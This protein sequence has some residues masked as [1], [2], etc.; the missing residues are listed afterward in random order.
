MM[1]SPN[2]SEIA[3]NGIREIVAAHQAGQARTDR[4]IVRLIWVFAVASLL[5]MVASLLIQ[6]RVERRIGE[7]A[8]AVVL[9]SVLPA[10]D[11]PLLCP[12]ETLRYLLTLN[13]QEPSVVEIDTAVRNMDTMVTVIPSVTRR[14]IYDAAGIAALPGNYEIPALM[15][16]TNTRPEAPWLPGQY[17]RLIAVTGVE[18][19]KRASVVSLNFRIADNCRG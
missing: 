6:Q 5:T 12:G 3:Q 13:I 18:G 9:V 17:R 4:H 2:L 15:P 19:D 8:P 10:E 1:G 16:A 14:A 7:P 11:N